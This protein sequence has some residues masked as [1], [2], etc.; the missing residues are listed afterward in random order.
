MNINYF[1][2]INIIKSV[3]PNMNQKG[4]GNTV[5]VNNLDSKKGIIG[6]GP[7][8]AAKSALDD[9]GD[10]LHQELYN[11]GINVT[12]I[13]PGRVDTPMIK[14]IK[15]SW[16]SPKISPDIVVQAIIKGI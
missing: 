14:N 9:F 16:I 4:R 10:V 11:K 3:L 1:G 6:D 2:T 5:V 7:Y 15:V 12:S 13:Y 8:V